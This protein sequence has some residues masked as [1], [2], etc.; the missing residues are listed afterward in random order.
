[1]RLYH[2][3]CSDGAQAIEA[4]GLLVPW[5]QPILGGTELAWLTDSPDPSRAELGFRGRVAGCDRLAYRVSV[6]TDEAQLWTEWAHAQRVPLTAR[7]MLDGAPSA[8]PG[9]WWV[10]EGPIEVEGV[11]SHS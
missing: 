8:R 6:D 3:T 4:A 10:S 5:P 9:S 7:L 11:A 1:M 2:Y